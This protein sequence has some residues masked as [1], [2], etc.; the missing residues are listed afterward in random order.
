MDRQ[1]LINALQKTIDQV[2][3]TAYE[4][5]VIFGLNAGLSVEDLKSLNYGKIVTHL[6][7]NVNAF[8]DAYAKHYET[9]G[10]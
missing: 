10:E 9:K 3:G 1:E 8:I 2:S 5:L 7:I 4:T 6:K